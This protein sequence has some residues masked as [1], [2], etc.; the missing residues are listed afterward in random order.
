MDST[1]VTCR[2]G[3][4]GAW[5][6]FFLPMFGERKWVLCTVGTSL[7]FPAPTQR[8]RGRQA[9]NS[10]GSS[11]QLRAKSKNLGGWR[12]R[13]EKHYF[14]KWN[15]QKSL[16]K[17][18]KKIQIWSRVEHEL[19]IQETALLKHRSW[20]M[21]HESWCDHWGC[22]C[23]RRKSKRKNEQRNDLMESLIWAVKSGGS[24]QPRI[25]FLIS[26]SSFSVYHIS[27][28]CIT[29]NLSYLPPLAMVERINDLWAHKIVLSERHRG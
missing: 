20:R 28:A 24:S 19:S 1:W 17:V 14:V 23:S 13:G 9:K 29:A 7:E 2:T 26:F 27:T 12:R 21:F 16:R 8:E 18:G 4:G 10:T 15:E 25:H 5:L 22:V 3:V 6:D 11:G